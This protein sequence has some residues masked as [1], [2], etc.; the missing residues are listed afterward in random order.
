MMRFFLR[1]AFVISV[2][3][4][5]AIKSNAWELHLSKEKKNGVEYYVTR[6]HMHW[7]RAFK[8]LKETA[9]GIGRN[10]AKRSSK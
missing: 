1:V 4:F 10:I 5:V 6:H 2:F 3:L 9:T 7:D 8:Y